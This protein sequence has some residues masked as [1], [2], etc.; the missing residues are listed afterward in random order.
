[1]NRAKV[2]R[3]VGGQ[4]RSIKMKL[5]SF[6]HFWALQI[7]DERNSRDGVERYKNWDWNSHLALQ[8]VLAAPATVLLFRTSSWFCRMLPAPF[9]ILLQHSHSPAMSI[10]V[11]KTITVT[12]SWATGKD[13]RKGKRGG[14]VGC[15]RWALGG[16]RWEWQRDEKDEQPTTLDLV[17]CSSS[18]KRESREQRRTMD[19]GRRTEGRGPLL[20]L[21]QLEFSN[22]SGLA[23]QQK[24]AHTP[25]K[26]HWQKIQ[27]S[28]GA[29]NQYKLLLREGLVKGFWILLYLKYKS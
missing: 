29:K 14:N 9:P 10:N 11:N 17:S 27:G 28:F 16:V 8:F 5:K 7:G 26:M 20:Q 19:G 22:R 21:S 6:A 18:C 4:M 24:P 3:K 12:C 13:N 1:M 23:T 25:S 2:G 15:E